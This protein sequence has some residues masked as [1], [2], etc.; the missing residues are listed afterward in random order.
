ICSD[1][2]PGDFESK[3]N[4]FPHAEFGQA[5]IQ[6][7]FAAALEA[8]QGLPVRSRS[9]WVNR[10]VQAF[11]RGPEEVLGI[12]ESV[13]DEWQYGRANG[14]VLFDPTLR[15]TG[16]VSNLAHSKGVAQAYRNRRFAAG[17]LAVAGRDGSWFS[18]SLQGL[19]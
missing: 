11:T 9:L 5:G 1:H 16:P 7:A 10:V 4:E 2:Q 8:G 19:R 18:S 15:S 6:Y 14:W 13:E 17:I 12:R 3:D